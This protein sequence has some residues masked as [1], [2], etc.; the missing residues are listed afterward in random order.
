MT[1]CL[2]VGGLGFRVYCLDSCCARL[3]ILLGLD[4]GLTSLHTELAMTAFPL[5]G[6]VDVGPRPFF[7]TLLAEEAPPSLVET[8]V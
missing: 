7:K 5:T 1:S 2:G 3:L 4:A 6:R 8:P